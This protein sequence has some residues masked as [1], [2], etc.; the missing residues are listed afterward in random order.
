MEI[1]FLMET[2]YRLWPEGFN[3][4]TRKHI[5][6]FNMS[7]LSKGNRVCGGL[8]TKLCLIYK[9]DLIITVRYK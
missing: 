3:P 1:G 8:T 9:W 7:R 5:S 4:L 2:T 6:L